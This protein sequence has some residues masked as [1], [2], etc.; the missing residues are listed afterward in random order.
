MIFMDLMGFV[1]Y[2]GFVDCVNKWILWIYEFKRSYGV[3]AQ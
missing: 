3:L 2:V 1:D